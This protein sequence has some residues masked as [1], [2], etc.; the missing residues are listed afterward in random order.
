[1]RI[2]CKLNSALTKVQDIHMQL[3]SVNIGTPQDIVIGSKVKK[4]GIFKLPTND[5]VYLN[6]HGHKGDAI[7]SKRHHGGP[8]QAVY[9]YT[10]ADYDWWETALGHRPT[11]GTFGENLTISDLESAT[12]CI[13]DRLRVGDGL[14]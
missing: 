14:L 11:P 12:V 4:T 7:Q 3:L 9:I 5:P 2:E 1:M 13:G 6:E 8:D 10:S